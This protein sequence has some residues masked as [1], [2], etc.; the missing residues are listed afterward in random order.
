MNKKFTA[1]NGHVT[2]L[3]MDN[4]VELFKAREA[5]KALEFQNEAGAYLRDLGFNAVVRTEAHKN[6]K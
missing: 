1:E 5:R 2:V 4:F 3:D 6:R